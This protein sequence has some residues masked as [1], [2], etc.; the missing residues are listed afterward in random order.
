MSPD[1]SQSDHQGR[2]A[3][4]SRRREAAAIVAPPFAVAVFAELAS[5]REPWPSGTAINAAQVDAHSAQQSN[6]GS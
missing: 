4:P 1:P 5:C 2:L 3:G 6:G